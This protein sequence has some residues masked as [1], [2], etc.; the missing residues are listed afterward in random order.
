V[1]I[2]DEVGS[3]KRTN[4]CGHDELRVSGYGD[5]YRWTVRCGACGSTEQW[6]QREWR[7]NLLLDD[8]REGI[9]LQVLGI[10]N[11]SNRLAAIS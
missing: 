2:G 8:S 1:A 5:D 7:E 6:T 4:I 11:E 9:P 3:V 10:G